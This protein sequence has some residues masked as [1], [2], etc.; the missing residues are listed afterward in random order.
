LMASWPMM[1]VNCM[2]GL[3]ESVVGNQWRFCVD[4]LRWRRLNE[5]IAKARCCP[6]EGSLSIQRRLAQLVESKERLSI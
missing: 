2:F 4:L 3:Y 1:S 6:A 5:N